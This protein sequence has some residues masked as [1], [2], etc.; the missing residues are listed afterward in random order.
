[1]LNALSGKVSEDNEF[2]FVKMR[3]GKAIV[4]RTVPEFLHNFRSFFM[5][6]ETARELVDDIT[7]S[8]SGY[9]AVLIRQYNAIDN[10]KKAVMT[11]EA[12][13]RQVGKIMTRE[14]TREKGA[15]SRMRRLRTG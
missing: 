6:S 2:S 3:K 15:K 4:T 7:D 8:K 13:D 5:Q 11:I 1:V 10:F 14:R 9:K 12:I